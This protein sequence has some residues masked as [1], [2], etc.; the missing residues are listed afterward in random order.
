M[1][2]GLKELVSRKTERIR[3]G[4]GESRGGNVLNVIVGWG[5]RGGGSMGCR[6]CMDRAVD[7]RSVCPLVNLGAR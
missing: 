5:I 2:A 7:R 3:F 4:L 6:L 1:S